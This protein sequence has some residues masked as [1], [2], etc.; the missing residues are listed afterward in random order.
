M[1]GENRYHRSM[2]HWPG[3]RRQAGLEAERIPGEMG[4]GGQG[5]Y[6]GMRKVTRAKGGRDTEQWAGAK[7][8]PFPAVLPPESLF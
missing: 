6:M 3:R 8:Q 2:S 1:E 4:C 5:M 7:R